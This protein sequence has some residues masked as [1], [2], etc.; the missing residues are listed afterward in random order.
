[1]KLFSP[2]HSKN[3]SNNQEKK[4]LTQQEFFV[5]AQELSKSPEPFPFP[6]IQVKKYA[7]MK[8]QE[9]PY[10]GTPYFVSIDEILE[11]FRKE[12]MKV[13]IGKE[14]LVYI[15][16]A[17]STDIQGEGILINCLLPNDT[18]DTRLRSLILNKFG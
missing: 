5:L 4:T 12:G 15:L 2:D 7:E 9:A 3:I 8:T 13:V 18:R 6:G 11:K 16:P 17:S 14:G 10:E 1:M